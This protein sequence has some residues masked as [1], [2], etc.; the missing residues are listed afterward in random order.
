MK[1][2]AGGV[3]VRVDDGGQIL[4]E[5]PAGQALLVPAAR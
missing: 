2:L 5:G 1:L 4:L 3:T